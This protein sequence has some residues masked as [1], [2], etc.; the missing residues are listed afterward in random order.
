MEAHVVA[1]RLLSGHLAWTLVATAALTAG[2]LTAP[3]RG[4]AQ[5]HDSAP[6]DVIQAS[7]I[8]AHVRFL[9]SDEMEGREAGT[10]G[11]DVA[12]NYVVSQ[13]RLLGLQ[14]AGDQGGYFQ[15][16]PLQA[17]WL[18]QDGVRMS[19]RRDGDDRVTL[20]SVGEDFV[21]SSSATA[22]TMTV[23][24]PTVFAGYGVTAPAF[25][26]DDY[27]GL[28][29]EGKIVVLL[30]GYP[31]FLPSEEGAHYGSGR[32][33]GRAAAAHGAIAVVTIYTERHETVAPWERVTANLDAMSMTWI[34]PDGAPFSAAPSIQASALMSPED[35]AVFFEGALQ[36]YDDVRA[37]AVDGAPEGFALPVSLEVTH[38]SRHERRSSANV[39]GVLEGGDPELRNEYVVIMGHLDHNGIGAPVDGDTIYN[40]AMD[41]AAGIGVLLEAARALRS[42][43]PA[44]RRSVL[45][46]AV[47]AEEKGMLGSEYFALNPTVPRESIV[48]SVNLDMPVLLYDFTD[49]IAFG[50]D[51][52]SLGGVLEAA[53]GQLGLT[54]TPDPMPEQAIFTRSDH[55]RFVQQGIPSVLLATGWNSTE[56]A[57]EGGRAFQGFLASVYHRPM[58]DLDQPID[59]QA[60]AKFAK[61]N[62]LLLRAIA[63]ADA[64]PT[65]NE[66]DFFGTLFR[67]VR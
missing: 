12:A 35:G 18:A 46:L 13:F 36:S 37:A 28:D 42:E 25:D 41:N 45:F 20:L 64:R 32:E 59:Y 26:H 23:S 56:G 16:V 66:R 44:P 39:V 8:E 61:V 51:H 6:E 43:A 27:E 7:A 55:Y 49:V 11:F 29:V 50:A 30:A 31:A 62:Y 40:G 19:I 67:S 52:S 24:A 4:A 58:D 9:A 1:R 15:R 10:R 3:A 60:G 54:V 53:V 48:A 47:T 57:G 33:K 2:A 22:S 63:N 5:A 17:H 38:T 14:P 34:G 65:W 21:V